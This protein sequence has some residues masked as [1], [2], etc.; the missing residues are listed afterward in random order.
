[1]SH[2]LKLII[3]K[4]KTA[5]LLKFIIIIMMSFLSCTQPGESEKLRFQ[6]NHIG[7]CVDSI[8][9]HSILKNKFLTDTF[10]YTKV[11]TDSTGS[12]ILILGK[13]H[14]LQIYP[15][16]GFFKNR[17]GAVTLLHHNFK[18]RETDTLLNYL[19]SFTKD[20]LFNRPYKSPE[21]N[22]DYINVYEDLADTAR[23]LK[24]IP[25]LQNHSKEN[26]LSWGYTSENL[27]NGITQQKYMDDYVGKET[28]LKLF[29][30]IQS[31]QVTI[32]KDE[33]K[34][35]PA[36]LK[37][38]GYKNEK[39]KFTLK[40]S[41]PVAVRWLKNTRYTSIQMKLSKPMENRTI[42]ISEDAIFIIDN[43][44][45]FFNYVPSDNQQ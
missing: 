27:K 29:Q 13:E 38:Y 40:G 11:V 8:T 31:I 36:L 9:F 45:A 23:L 5:T 2:F 33:Q 34:R 39:N 37:A 14:Y 12:E 7:L 24:F 3:K 15:E 42:R 26:Y 1:M 20:S 16:K 25:I 22:I 6:L 19:Q 18:W 43:Y 41:P 32:S 30:N 28:N 44:D 35:I 10:S 4:I 17:S 21:L